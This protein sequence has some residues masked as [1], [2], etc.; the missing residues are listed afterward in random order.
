MMNMQLLK[1]TAIILALS[2]TTLAITSCGDDDTDTEVT[3][4]KYDQ[5]HVTVYLAIYE[6]QQQYVKQSLVLGM[7]HQYKAIAWSDFTEV[8]ADAVPV[9]LS[10]IGKQAETQATGT[11]ESGKVKYF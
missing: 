8:S 6:N 3:V 10:A 2:T 4:Q 7:A 5:S 1:Y 9:A 11:T